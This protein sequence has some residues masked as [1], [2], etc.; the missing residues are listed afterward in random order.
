MERRLRKRMSVGRSIIA[1]QERRGALPG[2]PVDGWLHDVG[3]G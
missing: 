1:G 2:R 3:T